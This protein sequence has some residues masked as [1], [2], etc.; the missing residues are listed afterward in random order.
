MFTLNNIIL[1]CDMQK[2]GENYACGA[3]H[4]MN[5]SFFLVVF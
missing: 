1:I 4:I 3:C 5:L 2:E